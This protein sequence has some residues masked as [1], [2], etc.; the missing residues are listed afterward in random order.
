MQRFY[1]IMVTLRESMHFCLKH[2]GLN[3][4]V[5]RSCPQAWSKMPGYG[6]HCREIC[7]DGLVV[8]TEVCDD[9]NKARV[10]FP[11]TKQGPKIGH[12]LEGAR[13]TCLLRVAALL[14]K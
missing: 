7:G 4:T 11:D 10:S 1:R 8:G 2:S 14:P 5:A 13:S 3:V 9:G 6:S 12:C